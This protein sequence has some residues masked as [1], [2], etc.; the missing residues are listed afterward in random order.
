MNERGI[1]ELLGSMTA[2]A[3]PDLLQGIGD[4][5]AVIRK[6]SRQ[7]WLVTMDTLVES[8][9]FDR[10]W[11]PPD[12]LGRKAVSVNVSDIAAMGG[13]PLFLFLSLGMPP[14]FDARW[15][16]SFSRGLAD[17][18]RE[19]GCIL[20]GGDTVRSPAGMVV[21]VAVIG[22]T[23]TRQVV[24]RSGAK[25]GDSI[26]VSGHPGRAAAGLELCRL[27]RTDDPSFAGLVEA[28]LNPQ[29]RLELGRRLAE[30]RLIHAMMDLSDGLATD[31]AHICARSKVGAVVDPAGMRRDPLLAAAGLLDKDPDQWILSGG[32]DFELVFTA[33]CQHSAAIVDL[34][35]RLEVPV[36]RIGRIDDKQG[37]R[38]MRTLPGRNH[39]VEVDISFSGYDHFPEPR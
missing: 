22:E 39:S 26:W 30:N 9:H 36:A 27:G 8:V 35:A 11:H 31:L 3:A 5:C 32:E 6:N 18:C 21:T 24:L 10:N 2:A 37:V 12:K 1:I 17:A 23:P 38:A 7:S 33:A 4:D 34:A 16:T 25:A 29:P 19:Y 20:A 14:G 13:T 15:L 28:H